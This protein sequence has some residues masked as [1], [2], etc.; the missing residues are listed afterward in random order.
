[1]VGMS[2]YQELEAR[3]REITALEEVL[4]ITSW[5]EACMM[6]AGAGAGRGRAMATLAA[7]VHEKR[8]DPRIGELLNRARGDSALDAWQSAN[9]AAM[10][11][12]WVGATAIPVDL[13]RAFTT[14]TVAAEQAWRVARPHNDWLAA[15]PALETVV[16][17]ARERADALGAALGLSPYDA[18][19]DS[20]EPDLRL[21]DIEPVFEDLQTWLPGLAERVLQAQTPLEPLA[22]PFPIGAQRALCETAM[23][24]L[25]FDFHHGRF[26]VSHH[27]F[28]GGVPDDVRITTRYDESGF[29]DSLM[30]ICHETG[31]ALYQQGLP[32]AWRQQPV[33]QPLGAAVHESQSL[34]FE[35]QIC[36]GR[37][38]VGAIGSAIRAAF[39]R[40]RDDAWSDETLY[41]QAIRVERGR[42]RV[43]ADEVTYPLHVILRFELERSLLDGSLAV[44]DLPQAWHA[45]MMRYLGLP[46]LGDDRD[47]CMQDVHWFAG[48][49]GY[50]PTYTLGALG[51]AQ[52][53]AAARAA[54]PDLEHSIGR[55]ELA[56]LVGWLREHVHGQGRRLGMQALFEQVTGSPLGV[57]AF[58]A[59]LEHR[60]LG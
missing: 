15:R 49:F 31:H 46:T 40:E 32:I 21:A 23:R 3:A 16:R 35:M 34:L 4:A 38:F 20:W 19:L 14:A 17:L 48:L 28:C 5:D 9:L 54:L 51:A 41:Q 27:P 45:G 52:W 29:L 58:K 25:G 60:Y 18:L 6:P 59:H 57:A 36:R 50:F 1:M 42:I 24:V 56:P 10:E 13:V 8:I 39:G 11:R 26:D 30:A 37:A 44:A 53:F 47:G 33:G 22:G 7:L 55:G 12:D 2:A 43:D